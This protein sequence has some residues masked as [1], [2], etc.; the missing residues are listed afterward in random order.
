ML[1]KQFKLINSVTVF[2]FCFKSRLSNS[3][4]PIS[5]SYKV[6]V[7]LHCH[8]VLKRAYNDFRV[9]LKSLPRHEK[10]DWEFCGSKWIRGYRFGLQCS[11]DNVFSIIT[12]GQ[13]Q[14]SSLSCKNSFFLRPLFYSNCCW[15]DPVPV[16]SK[17]LSKKKLTDSV[18]YPSLSLFKT[19]WAREILQSKITVTHCWGSDLWTQIRLL[20]NLFSTI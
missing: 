4:H 9:V 5:A 17:D 7:F 2:T 16:L 13:K 3:S 6:S 10:W 20:F 1:R 18:G 12:E 14:I 19:T 15:F 8:K 11:Q